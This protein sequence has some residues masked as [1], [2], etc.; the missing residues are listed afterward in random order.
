MQKRKRYSKEFKREAVQM[1]KDT[2][3]SI[4]QVAADLGLHP[5]VLSRW[6]REQEGDEEQAFHGPEVSREEEVAQQPPRRPSWSRRPEVPW[7]GE[8]AQLKRELARVTRERNFLKEAVAFF[9]R[10]AARVM[11]PAGDDSSGQP[12]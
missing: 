10:D 1:T 12:H 4:R 9:A 6:C 5:T 8:V 11:S 3:L 7:D 2:D